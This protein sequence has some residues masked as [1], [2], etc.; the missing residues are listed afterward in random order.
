MAAYF[1]GRALPEFHMI[2][3]EGGF[4]GPEFRA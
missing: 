4:P 2:G 3:G 1:R